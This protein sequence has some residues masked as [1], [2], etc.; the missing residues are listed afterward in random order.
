MIKKGKANCIIGGQWGSCGKGKLAGW[1]YPNYPEISIAVSDFTP[2]AGHTFVEDDGRSYVSKILPMGLLF[3]T[4]RTVIIGPHAVFSE[5]R[6]FEEL[7]VFT[8]TNP[9]ADVF[10]HPLASVLTAKN[11]ADENRQLRHIASTM[12]GSAAAAVAK[13]MRDPNITNFAKNSRR[14]RCMV[15]DTHEL[16]QE[17]LGKGETAL[18]ETGQGFDLGLN[19]GWEWPYVTGRDTMLGRT[20]DSA[21][22]HPN[23][24]GSVIV[25]LRTYPIRVG[26]ISGGSSGGCH[27]DQAELSW[28]AISKELGYTVSEYTTVTKR[29]RRVFT[30]SDEQVV[31]MLRLIKPDYAFL[32]YVN[33]WPK[34][35]VEERLALVRNL[36]SEHD[37]TLS[38]LGFGAKQGEMERE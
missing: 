28:E 35:K 26:C 36:L 21:G 6:L 37:C 33:Y 3:E 4:V 15:V 22:V 19:N 18:I 12:Q 30:W 13:I 20:L 10:I 31:R 34:E 17:R 38:L 11:V 29:L 7:S 14:L 9:C 2:N 24:L 27:H 1:L 32:N 23:Q 16:M 25:A 5:D 8:R